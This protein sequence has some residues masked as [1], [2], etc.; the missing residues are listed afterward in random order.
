MVTES[1]QEFFINNDIEK[2]GSL[3]KSQWIDLCT[4][5]EINLSPQLA[6]ALFDGLDTDADGQVRIEDIMKELLA[7]EANQEKTGITP[8]TNR[9]ASSLD[10]NLRNQGESSSLVSTKR[11]PVVRESRK[12]SKRL[13]ERRNHGKF[14]SQSSSTHIDDNGEVFV[15][16][17]EFAD[18]GSEIFSTTPVTLNP[19]Y[20]KL[21]DLETEISRS[22]PQLLP[23]FNNVMEDFRTELIASRK[24]KSALEQNYL[25][26][27]VAR[28][29]DL[30]FLED[31]LEGQIQRIKEITI[32]EVH[33]IIRSEY[34]AKIMN[35]EKEIAEIRSQV[36]NLRA[37]IQSRQNSVENTPDSTT[38]D[39]WKNNFIPPTPSPYLQRRKSVR[40]NQ[41]ENN[42]LMEI[43]AKLELREAELAALK[44]QLVTQQRQ[45]LADRCELLTREEEKMQLYSKLQNLQLALERQDET[46]I[47]SHMHELLPPSSASM[48]S[49]V[50]GSSIQNT[51]AELMQTPKPPERIF[52]IIL[53]GDTGVGKSS[54]MHQ[55]CDGVFYPRLRATVGVDFRTRNLRLDRTVYSIQLWDTAGQEKY[56][57]IVRTYFRKVDGVIIMYD[58]TA[59][60]TFRNVRSWMEQLSESSNGNKVPVI[61]VGNKIDL[62]SDPGSPSY[63]S[64]EMGIKLAESYKALFIET[65]VC[66]AMNVDEA[67]RQLACQ[68]KLD[69]DIQVATVQLTEKPI[70]PARTCCKF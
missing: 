70:T 31:E 1:L 36:N 24:E 30:M 38:M 11:T 6:S 40:V 41:E 69:E 22:Y 37:K 42:Q 55:F 68:M 53:I 43:T 66:T 61:I 64:T 65:S 27:K 16:K 49:T 17:K 62:R 56:R 34:D 44:E 57:S 48:I 5:E 63:V 2:D 50:T 39:I 18:D 51:A 10:P 3:N 13:Y 47:Q 19:R 33:D 46:Q 12:Q 20:K 67:V 60:S 15:T 28:Q 26:E 45:M 8:L 7:Y 4:R 21:Q 52:K 9:R 23:T 58:V 29:K 59:P 14:L 35:K 32:N 54:F 25:Q